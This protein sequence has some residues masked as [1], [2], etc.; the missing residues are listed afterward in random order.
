[1][2]KA[3]VYKADVLKYSVH[4]TPGSFFFSFSH[5]LLL[6]FLFHGFASLKDGGDRI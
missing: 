3:K 5:C 2:A 4:T 6:L 1:M